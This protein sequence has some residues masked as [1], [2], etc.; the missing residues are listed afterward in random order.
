MTVM[1]RQHKPTDKVNIHVVRDALYVINFKK[2]QI[3]LDKKACTCLLYES[4]TEVIK[5]DFLA[6]SNGWGTM[7]SHRS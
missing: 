7:V 2:I 4:V 3:A 5:A 6:K 1:L